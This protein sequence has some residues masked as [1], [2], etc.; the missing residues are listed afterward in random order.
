MI[1]VAAVE[2]RRRREAKLGGTILN[3][4]LAVIG[5]AALAILFGFALASFAQTGSG[6]PDTLPNTMIAPAGSSVSETPTAPSSPGESA[7]K[8]RPVRRRATKPRPV[9]PGK[10]TNSVVADFAADQQALST[11]V[12]PAKGHLRI[13]ADSWAYSLPD[14][15]SAQLEAMQA[16]KYV[17]VTGTT[18]FFLQ[19]RLKSGKTGY[20]PYD[21]VDYLTP[22]DRIFRLTAN[23]S[24]LSAPNHAAK[25]L[26][27]VHVGH[28]VHVVGVALDYMKI[29]M[30]D[31]LE[32]FIPTSALE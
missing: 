25:K 23:A 31:G 6:V 24:V 21:A 20:V 17:N 9:I 5:L 22:T 10:T 13:I 16:G 15:R 28:D 3:G 4:R 19:V 27:E 1:P 12:E 8:P 11:V 26:A 18:R 7:E 32:G 2:E 30:R 29:R 14:K